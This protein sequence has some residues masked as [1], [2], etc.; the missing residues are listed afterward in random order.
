M[1]GSV[2]I[3]TIPSELIDT[4]PIAWATSRLRAA[5]E[6]AEGTQQLD[7]AL[8]LSE[9]SPL[10]GYAVTAGSSPGSIEIVGDAPGLRHGLGEL[11]DRIEAGEAPIDAGQRAIGL[12]ESA[13]M[14]VRSIARS[15]SSVDEDL[16]WFRDQDFWRGYLDWLA[17]CRFSRFHLALGMQY[18][19]GA[20][21]HGATD[22]Y[23]CFAYPFLL[24]V[25]GYDVRAEGVDADERAKNLEALQFIARETKR[26]GMW[27]QLGLWNHAYDYGRD[28][29]HRF[30]IVGLT[31][32]N[33]AD[34]SGDALA[35]L[36]RGC[37]DIDG[38]TLRVH[39]EGG[40][41]DEAHEVFWDRVFAGASSVGRD[42]EVDMHAKG[43][44]QPLIDAI[45]KPGLHPVLSAKY[46]AEH[47]GLPYHQTSIR[48]REAAKPL[49]PGH[50]LKG[51]TEF[52]RRFT[53]YGY[54]DFLDDDRQTDLVFRIW[55]GTQK[56]LLWG[57]PA[58]AAGYGR[59]STFGGA[60]GVDV[61]EPLFFK[62]RKGSGEPGKRD[63]YADP[64]L[65]LGRE[66]WKKYRYSYLLWGRLLY[67]PNTPAEV[68][69]RFLRSEYGVLAADVEG[70]LSPLSR[71]L[72]LVTVVHGVG[73]SNN[74]NWVEMA[75]S[76][77][78]STATDPGHFGSDTER[79]PIWE[80]VSAFDPTLFATI[81]EFADNLVAGTPTAKYT[82][83][84]VAQWLDQMVDAADP[85]LAALRAANSTDPQARRTLL[86]ADVL[87][88]L[89]RYFAA[90]FKAAA[91]YAIYRRTHDRRYLERAVGEYRVGRDYYAE[92]PKIVDGVYQND[93]KFGPEVSEHGHWSANVDAID[94]DLSNLEREL[95]EDVSN[96]AADRLLAPA[97]RL[98][99]LTWRHKRPERFERGQELRLEIDTADTPEIVAAILH[100]RH[101]NQA[102]SFKT[103]AMEPNTAGFVGTI[104]G[105]YTD[106]PYGLMYFFEIRDAD[107]ATAIYPGL[108]DE[109]SDQPYV[110]V[111]SSAAPKSAQ[112]ST[113]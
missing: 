77:P 23:L 20:D 80:T 18:N 110:T 48:N 67:N 98:N 11:A 4:E 101:V 58:I 28:S 50:S 12:S 76:L 54:A 84:D 26:R 88:C 32:E 55:P 111:F 60:L 83:V 86:D 45:Q 103:R 3:T 35:E 15:F 81:G 104:D 75:V 51:I 33:H 91:D 79:P 44:D 52:S 108:N 112:L 74:G 29:V 36:L 106:K 96:A 62:G 68:W 107:G 13:A 113:V 38:L 8:R 93:L 105:S 40:I 22:N 99:T 66:D 24:D 25:D 43:V 14:P 53:R 7:L 56:L 109:L 21:K 31:P 82:A 1:P 2:S 78:I 70:A 42:I 9:S 65:Q 92:I 90:K 6:A 47:M 39:Y 69:Q 27:F 17:A 41:A 19:Y 95:D 63:P 94:A 37:P 30:P 59:L 85:H 49:P 71:I 73:G 100:Y 16:P 34:Y 87:A 89:G 46:W 64:D 61:C 10:E 72:P 97:G 102:E 5:T 57:D